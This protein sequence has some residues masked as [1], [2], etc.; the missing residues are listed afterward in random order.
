MKL[1]LSS[2]FDLPKW[3]G[4]LSTA[5]K[6]LMGP[7]LR[8]VPSPR[9]VHLPLNMEYIPLIET[10]WMGWKLAESEISSHALPPRI[11]VLE[12]NPALSILLK[13]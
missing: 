10:I 8:L 6:K 1:S 13:S 3:K 12:S 2:P 9:A 4:M 5:T 11:D 7:R